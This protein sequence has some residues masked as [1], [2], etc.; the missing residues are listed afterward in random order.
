MKVYEVI[1]DL[2][3]IGL[4]GVLVHD[5]LNRPMMGGYATGE[6]DLKRVPVIQ[7]MNPVDVTGEVRVTNQPVIERV[8]SAEAGVIVIGQGEAQPPATKL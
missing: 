6:L 4:L 1:R 7:V 2:V 3:V 5:A 8:R